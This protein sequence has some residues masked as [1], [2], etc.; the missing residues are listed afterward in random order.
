MPSSEHHSPKA[1]QHVKAISPEYHTPRKPEWDVSRIVQALTAFRQDIKD[2]HARMT[3]YIIES[4]K[5]VERRVLTG[6]DLFAGLS[7][8]PALAD[9][10]DTMRIKFKEHSMPKSNKREDYY[11]VR[12]IQTD[13]DRVPRYRFH[14]VE[15]KKNILTPNTMLTF[16]PH[17]RDLES[18]EQSKYEVWLQELEDIDR[19]SGFKPMSR[20]EKVRVTVR[21]EF[22]STVSLYLE[23]WLDRLRL[24]G[25]DKSTLIRYMANRA[26][27]AAITPRQK[28]DILNAHPPAE[29]STPPEANRAVEMFTEAF[30]RVFYQNESSTKQISLRDVLLLDESVDS[31]MD[32]KPT[33]K[34]GSLSLKRKRI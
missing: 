25:C 7:S 8:K 28:S 32:T 6:K 18:S 20:E 30:H 11:V 10:A 34:D 3:S 4:T 13:E 9:E 15:I 17:L 29:S 26:P 12:P 1:I 19:K 31:I 23:N 33:A 5:P 21:S 27:D 22:A 16:V 14:H 2:G 24:P